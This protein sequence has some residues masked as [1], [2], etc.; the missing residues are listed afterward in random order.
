M[1]E[2]RTA[3]IAIGGNALSPPGERSTISDQFHHT[4]ESLGPIVDLASDGWRVVVTG[5]EN[6]LVPVTLEVGDLCLTIDVCGAI[7][8]RDADDGAGEVL[9]R[10]VDNCGH[11][12]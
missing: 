2:T 1:T 9:H 8:K 12:Y 7:D 11:H 10:G 6:D 4:R 3:V 5:R